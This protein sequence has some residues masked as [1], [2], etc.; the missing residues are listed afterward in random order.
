VQDQSRLARSVDGAGDVQIVREALGE[1]LPGVH[2]R[3]LGDIGVSPVCR[4]TELVAGAAFVQEIQVWPS[5]T[6]TPAEVATMLRLGTCNP[7]STEQF[8]QRRDS[9]GTKP[10]QTGQANGRTNVWWQSASAGG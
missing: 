4:G 6:A 3:G 9:N 2:R 5:M 10:R 7:S 1:V 8:E